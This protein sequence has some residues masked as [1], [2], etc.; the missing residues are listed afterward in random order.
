MHGLITVGKPAPSL[1][2]AY[3]GAPPTCRVIFVHDLNSISLKQMWFQCLG[4]FE[5]FPR[6][7]PALALSVTEVVLWKRSASF[8]NN[9]VNVTE[10]RM[11]H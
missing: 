7:G 5:E 6:I 3:F 4:K 9:S 10:V 11:W 8:I 1:L 2:L